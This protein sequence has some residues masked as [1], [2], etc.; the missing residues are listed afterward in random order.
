MIRFSC[1]FCFRQ[2]EGTK[3]HKDL[4]AYMAA[5]K[6]KPAFMFSVFSSILVESNDEKSIFIWCFEG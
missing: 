6:S 1:F 4:K 5:V 3:L 2:S